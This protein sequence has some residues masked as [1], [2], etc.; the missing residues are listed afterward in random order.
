VNQ[1]EVPYDRAP[2]QQ[3]HLTD[4]EIDDVVAFLNALTDK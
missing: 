1:E 2:G 3:P 4:A